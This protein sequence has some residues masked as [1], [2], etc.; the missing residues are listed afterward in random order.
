MFK[1][2]VKIKVIVLCAIMQWQVSNA[3][4][5]SLIGGTDARNS[6]RRGLKWLL[7]LS[8][9][10]WNYR[11]GLSSSESSSYRFVWPVLYLLFGSCIRGWKAEMW[12]HWWVHAHLKCGNFLKNVRNDYTHFGSAFGASAKILTLGWT[13]LWTLKLSGRASNSTRNRPFLSTVTYVHHYFVR[14][15]RTG[16]AIFYVPL[17]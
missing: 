15:A 14:A 12:R 9:P 1:I 7:R 6:N 13:N 17:H 3:S 16:T 5:L 8:S 11:Y 2:I 10:F 4:N